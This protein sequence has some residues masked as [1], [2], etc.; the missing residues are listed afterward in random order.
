MLVGYRWGWKIRHRDYHVSTSYLDSLR[1]EIDDVADDCLLALR[2]AGI[3]IEN[4]L[5]SLGPNYQP[6]DHSEYQSNARI[7]KFLDEVYLVPA[8]VDWQVLLHGQLC[9]L[10]NAGPAGFGLLYFSLIGGFSAPKI[11]KVLDATNYMTSKNKDATWRRL[12][13]TFQMVVGCMDSPE[14]MKPGQ[15][16]WKSVLKVRF[17]HS[18]VR[19]GILSRGTWD[20]QEYG[21][22]INQED[23]VGTILSFSVNVLDTI[24][25]MTG[26][27]T[28]ADQEAYL[29][30]WRY[31]GCLMGIKEEYNP[32]KT[33]E[34]AR[35][36]TESVILH[37]LHPDRRSGEVARNVLQAVS[38]RQERMLNWSY[39]AHS[40]MARLLL[41]H[42]LANALGLETSLVHRA[43]VYWVFGLVYV[44]SNVFG[45]FIGDKGVARV[46]S[47]LKKLIATALENT[48]EQSHYSQHT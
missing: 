2:E 34:T 18:R 3:S 16:G 21:L 43:Y 36:T 35:G 33:L 10:R 48:R 32:C 31:I 4:F 25:R 1:N 38:G 23:M 27:L 14:C 7:K 42:P 8:Y 28:R 6:D 24:Q 13:E 41:G 46:K 26:R 44:L 19:L 30:L 9:F 37:L 5:S 22:P 29:H 40:E 20:A 45:P 11:V 39:A 17:L 12:N 15:S 47:A